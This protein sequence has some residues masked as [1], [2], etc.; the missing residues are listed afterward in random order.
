MSMCLAK[1]IYIC[2][3]SEIFVILIINFNIFNHFYIV[4]KKTLT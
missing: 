3:A 1:Y 4:K 2:T